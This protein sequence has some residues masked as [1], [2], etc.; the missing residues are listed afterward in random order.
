MP[1]L[2]LH[3]RLEPT[4]DS[5]WHRHGKGKIPMDV[6]AYRDPALTTPAARWSW[7]LS[8]R[9]TRRNKRVMFNCY[10]WQVTWHPALLPQAK[11]LATA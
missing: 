7:D 9:P 4:T 5:V 8:T 3:L 11:P 10:A 1:L 2:T 6:V